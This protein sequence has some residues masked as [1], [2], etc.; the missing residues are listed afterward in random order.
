MNKNNADVLSLLMKNTK[1]TQ[2]EISQKLK[3]SL[4]TVN[5]SIQFLKHNKFLIYSNEINQEM[6]SGYKV[7]NAIILAAG[8]GIRMIPINKENPKALLTINNEVIIE[9]L[10][11]QLK[12][13]GI[14]NIF[15]VVGFQKEKFE[16]LI[17]KYNV[18]LIV[19]NEYKFHNNYLS[20]LKVG[21]NLGNSYI[22]PADIILKENIFNSYEFCS[23]YAV[24]DKVSRIGY[25]S[26]GSHKHLQDTASKG[27]FNR[28]VGVAYIQ[29]EYSKRLLENLQNFYN[30]DLFNSYWENALFKDSKIKIYCNVIKDTKFYEINTYEDLRQANKNSQYLLDESMKI[31]LNVFKCNV[32]DIKDILPL[33]SGMTNRSYSFCYK[34][35]KYIVRIPGE[36]TQELI[37]RENEFSVYNAISGLNIS[38]KLVYFDKRNGIKITEF[39][40]DA[41]NCDASNVEQVKKCMNKLHEFHDM[42][43]F[44]PHFFNLKENILYYEKL[45]N[46]VPSLYADY[47]TTKKK[48]MRL[49]DYI[50]TLSIQYCLCHIDSVSDNFLF[51]PEGLFLIDWEYAA[52]QDPCV[53]I[54]MFAIYSGYKRDAIDDLIIS[55]FNMIPDENIVKRIYAYVAICGFLWS[56]WCEYK[57]SLGIEFGDYSLIQYRYAKEYSKIVID[58]LEG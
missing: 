21:N 24:T 36:G 51:S 13:N 53:D 29:K 54:A 50:D 4:G 28:A 2:R 26:V 41:Q 32:A 37:N 23:W 52:M 15:I 48:I 27:M 34:D 7:K 10:I 40:Y 31:I 22:L 19:N 49:L 6:L 56:N 12:I 3:L 57:Y 9:R 58:W 44:V 33:K 55:Y 38:D 1:L 45:R 5:S 8:Y 25:Y 20:L 16:Y 14:S 43:L 18:E 11:E 47:E 30:N 39:I 17:D 46:G 35:K 42:K